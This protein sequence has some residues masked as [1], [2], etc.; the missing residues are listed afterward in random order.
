[1]D[2]A[3]GVRDIKVKPEMNLADADEAI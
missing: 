1:M 3:D 2:L